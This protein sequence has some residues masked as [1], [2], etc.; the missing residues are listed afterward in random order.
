MQKEIFNLF[1][2][3]LY[4][5]FLIYR[6]ISGKGF[7]V[8]NLTIYAL[9]ILFFFIIFLGSFSLLE[10]NEKIVGFSWIFLG[11]IFIYLV[12]ILYLQSLSKPKQK[13]NLGQAL[14]DL[15]ANVPT[16]LA[17]FLDCPDA[18]K[19]ID[20]S[21][22][23][24]LRK[25]FKEMSP[26]I[27]VLALSQNKKGKFIF[28]RLGIGLDSKF[29]Q[30]LEDLATRGAISNEKPI[31][32]EQFQ[33]VI[34]EAAKLTWENRRASIEVGDLILG[35]FK[36]S[37]YSEKIFS[38][39]KL[40]YEDLENVVY[41]QRRWQKRLK[42]PHFYEKHPIVGIGRD[43][44]AG[45]TPFLNYF[46]F[47]ISN[48]LAQKHLVLQIF[49]HNEQI[50]AAE[51]TLLGEEK[52]NVLLVGLPGVGKKTIVNGLAFNILQGNVDQRLRY[53]NIM[54]LDVNNLISGVKNRAELERRLSS[55]FRDMQNA[56]NII[57]FIDKLEALISG[58]KL[59]TIDASQ[60]LSNY[61]SR[62]NIRII[63]AIDP[64][65]YSQRLIGNPALLNLFEKIDVLEP[66]KSDVADILEEV[67]PAIE[68]KNQVF[69]LYQTLQEIVRLSDKYIKNEP[70]PQKA[71][72]LLDQAAAETKNRG[73]KIVLPADIDAIVKEKT[74]I[75]VGAI[76]EKEKEKLLNLEK[77]LHERIIDQ[78]EAIK[79]IADALRRARAGVAA[80]NRPI[81]K[82]LFLGS[83]GV[84]KTETAKALAA[85]YYNSEKNIIRFDMSEFQS[86]NTIARL[87]G[88]PLSGQGVRIGGQLTDAVKNNPFSVVLLDE[89]EK[90]HPNVLNLFLSVLD[91]GKLTDANGEVIDFTQTFIIATSNAGSEIIREKVTQGV[92][93]EI[94]RAELL[95]KL[96]QM[97]IFK[98]EF[99]NRFDGVII[100]KPL[101]QND[102]LAI[103]RLLVEGLKKQLAGQEIR[104]EVNE[105]A[106]AKLA[107]A[108]Y[109]PEY[110][111]RELKRVIAE[112]LE[113]QISK[114]I[115]SGVAGRGKTITFTEREIS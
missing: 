4:Q 20:D 24:A 46:A 57:L 45:Y 40:K 73:A 103:T 89:I 76:E 13:E 1:Q 59:S 81:G 72:N 56:G 60:V 79:S 80:E 34:L 99:L 83:T 55:V 107:A 48:F 85:I 42:T 47:N 28:N 87:I 16:N 88:Q 2:S 61:L 98:P 67:I 94:F 17:E 29:K 9:G 21:Y 86:V 44:S 5:N 90:A 19:V 22:D 74:K 33:D 43:W 92:A 100:Y 113:N 30:V 96:Q 101:N 68:S 91:E 77:Y 7:I 111:A 95:D 11:I 32:G 62:P 14:E 110:G 114:L 23:F 70:F 51:R 63:A 49:G 53:Q 41:W 12:Y 18:V 104:L 37:K 31:F 64:T 35:V 115:L 58:E 25:S 78:D 26:E 65:N 108:G 102:V 84:G 15:R 66:E 71:I 6:K 38:A 82:F 69:I 52:H 75:P 39:A 97:G 109:S 8:R 106:I 112:R 36:I 105:G 93:A 27:L 54:Q 3:Q 10:I 50:E